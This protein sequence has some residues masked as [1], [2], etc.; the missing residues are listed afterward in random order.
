MSS[1]LP[2]RVA[3][4]HDW[5]DKPGG[6]ERVLKE[7]AQCFPAADIFAVADTMSNADR[8]V[9]L[10]KPVST[11]FIQRLPGAQRHFRIYLPLMPLA[12]EQLDLSKYDVVISSSWAV[13]KGVITSA[14]QLHIAYVHTPIRY[15]WDQQHDYLLQGGIGRGIK[16]MVARMALHWLR[17]W[18]VRTANGVDVWL[19]NSSNVARR[20]RKTYGKT[21]QVLHPPIAVECFPFAADK[22]DFY[23]TCS[24][25]VPYKRVD[26]IVEAFLKRPDRQLIVIGD[27]PE[28]GALGR[29]AR[30]APN[31]SFL[32]RQTDNHVRKLMSDARAFVFAANEDFGIT[33]LEAQACGTPV[34]AYGKGGALETIR[35][36]DAHS[37]TGCFFYEQTADA[38]VSVIDHFEQLP[39][40]IDPASCRANAGRFRAEAF[41]SKLQQIV[42]ENCAKFRAAAPDP[43]LAMVVGSAPSFLRS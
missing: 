26:L 7:I 30:S 28:R 2:H 31:I 39:D 12:I 41:R 8:A 3:I 14:D 29:L 21:A 1:P 18:D 38:L 11:S 13:A 4:V 42:R 37:P 6:A 10:G 20:I 27:G 43:D 16:S 40:Q 23:L 34:I 17:I 33:P 24:R 15:A 5:L 35:G 32:G 9:I 36:L 19:A 25:L 22:Q